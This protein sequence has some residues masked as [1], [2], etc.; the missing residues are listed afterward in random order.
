MYN[1]FGST[2]TTLGGDVL[3]GFPVTRV[4]G[5]QARVPVTF[6]QYADESDPG[7]LFVASLCLFSSVC[8]W[9][10]SCE[11]KVLTVHGRTV[12]HSARRQD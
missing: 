5:S 12:P 4:T 2:I 3:A 7:A 9:Y 11:A 1:D 8:I 10:C 6:D